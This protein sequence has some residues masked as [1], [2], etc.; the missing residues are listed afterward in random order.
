MTGSLA[1]DFPVWREMNFQI[2]LD[3]F[4]VINH[5]NFTQPNSSLTVS[6][7]TNSTVANFI[8]SSSFGQIT[9]TQP[10]RRLQ[11]SGRFFF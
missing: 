5:T 4:N 1:K 7:T 3:A 2:R 10:Q 6:T 9:G 8:N 11:L